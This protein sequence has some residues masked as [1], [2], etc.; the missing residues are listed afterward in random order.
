MWLAGLGDLA[1]SRGGGEVFFIHSFKIRGKG[2]AETP[3]KQWVFRGSVR[4]QTVV[5]PELCL[6][7]ILLWLKEG[8]HVANPEQLSCKAVG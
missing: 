6:R 4:G 2:W 7:R 8:G 5:V 1:T 3:R